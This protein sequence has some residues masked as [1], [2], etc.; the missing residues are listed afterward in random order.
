MVA[1]KFSPRQ[2][3]HS[4]GVQGQEEKERNDKL[5]WQIDSAVTGSDR[6]LPSKVS[7]KFG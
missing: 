5:N 1:R 4:N 3:R 2:S 6:P 7:S